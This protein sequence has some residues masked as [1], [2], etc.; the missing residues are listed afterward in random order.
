MARP[1]R[2]TFVAAGLA[3]ILS[4]AAVPALAEHPPA[5]FTLWGNPCT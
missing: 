1:P 2:S 3:V 5:F 4:L